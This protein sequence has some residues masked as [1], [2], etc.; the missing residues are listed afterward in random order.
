MRDTKM[1]IFHAIMVPK[2]SVIKAHGPEEEEV[3]VSRRYPIPFGRKVLPIQQHL[4][5]DDKA[6]L[7]TW[8][9]GCGFVQTQIGKTYMTSA[10]GLL[11]SSSLSSLCN[12]PCSQQI[13]SLA[14]SKA[15]FISKTSS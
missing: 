12:L 8:S 1:A 6:D 5:I 7:G 14:R 10:A 13:I 15:F 11:L 4:Y 9:G 2:E 3:M